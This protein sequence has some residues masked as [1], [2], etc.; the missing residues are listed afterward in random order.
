MS[1]QEAIKRTGDLIL[2]FATIKIVSI[3]IL[4]LLLLIPIFM[5]TSLLEERRYRRNDV[6]KEIKNGEMNN[7]LFVLFLQYRINLFIKIKMIHCNMRLNI[8][9]F[10]RKNWI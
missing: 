7:L 10:C 3:G 6:V 1:T 9:M 2:N 5:T 8:F 4:I